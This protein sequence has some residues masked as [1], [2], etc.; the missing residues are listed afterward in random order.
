MLQSPIYQSDLFVIVTNEAHVIPK[1]Y[2][3]E[4]CCGVNLKDHLHLIV[5]SPNW[6]NTYLCVAKVNKNLS[7]TFGWLVEKLIVEKQACPRT[8]VYCKTTK[9][10]GQLFSF[11]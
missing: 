8:L 7:E 4:C 11:F 6:S 2:V 1:W 9:E 10:C 5:A 3:D